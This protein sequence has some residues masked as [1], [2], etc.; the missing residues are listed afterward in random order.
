LAHRSF[1]RN[2]R[3]MSTAQRRPTVALLLISVACLATAVCSSDGQSA[4]PG[5]A[6]SDSVARLLEAVPADARAAVGAGEPR[7]SAYWVQWSTCGE[8]SRA[9]TA[10]ANGGRAAGWILVDDL[11]ADPGI[12][13][14]GWPVMT[15][16]DAIVV[17]EGGT[18]DP[19]AHLARQL[20]TAKLNFEAGS[21]RCQAAS[22]LVVA[23]DALLASIEQS[24]AATAADSTN[25]ASVAAL[26]GTYNAGVLC[27]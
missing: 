4:D 26:L 21:G 3:G 18:A 22:D 20:F 6:A 1:L 12:T 7:S 11:L 27:Q 15:C 14:G 19:L 8:D 16:R 2:V 24:G 9:E 23:G 13:L 25:A 17:L 5:S 10:T